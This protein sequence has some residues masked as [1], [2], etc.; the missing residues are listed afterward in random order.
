MSTEPAAAAIPGN[1]SA[2]TATWR[3][4][5]PAISALDGTH[6]V[7]T[8]VPPMVPRSIIATDFPRTVAWM[9][10]ANAAPPE[11]MTARSTFVCI[12]SPPGMLGKSV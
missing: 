5:A 10:A 11:P 7:F 2:S 4:S 9:A 1:L 12:R 8:Q 3:A 6:P